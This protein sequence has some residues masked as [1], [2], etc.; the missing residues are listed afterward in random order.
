MRKP[1]LPYANNKGADQPAHLH[2]LISAFVVHCLDSISPF[3]ISRDFKPLPSFYDCADQFESTLIANPD[4]RFSRDV[5]QIYMR[6]LQQIFVTK[7]FSNLSI[8]DRLDIIM[9]HSKAPIL[10]S[11]SFNITV[12]IAFMPNLIYHFYI[13]LYY[14]FGVKACLI[15]TKW[16]SVQTRQK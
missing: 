5:G 8:Q 6:T 15:S 1:V 9:S 2:S 11:T 10:S 3:S 7:V 16:R 12:G 14:K 13:N 4:D